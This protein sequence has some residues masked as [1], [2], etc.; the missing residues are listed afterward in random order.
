MTCGGGGQARLAAQCP[1]YKATPPLHGP[2]SHW[3]PAA[4]GIGQGG[5]PGWAALPSMSVGVR[6]PPTPSPF[7]TG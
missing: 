6:G 7:T 4:R 3:A 2:G 1:S 5:M